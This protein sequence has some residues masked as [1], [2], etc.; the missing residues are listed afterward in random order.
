MMNSLT[1]AA[2]GV[3]ACGCTANFFAAT[4]EVTIT[5]CPKHAAAP[6]MFEA[7]QDALYC[8]HLLN[9]DDVSIASKINASRVSKEKIQAA[10]E[11][12]TGIVEVN[13]G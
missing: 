5:Y 9:Q 7:L 8:I 2:Q 6:A 11:L 4:D 3:Y 13:D 1:L 10:I 12:A